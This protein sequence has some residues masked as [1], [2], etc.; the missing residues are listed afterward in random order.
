VYPHPINKD[1]C[2]LTLSLTHPTDKGKPISGGELRQ[3]L[4]D[5]E[6]QERTDFLYNSIRDTLRDVAEATRAVDFKNKK[7]AP[8]WL[9]LS[10]SFGGESP[11]YL[12][13]R[14]CGRNAVRFQHF[15]VDWS[16]DAGTFRPW[17]MEIN[18]GPDFNVKDARDEQIKSGFMR[19]VWSVVGLRG[20]THFGDAAEHNLQLVFDSGEEEGK[21]RSEK[22]RRGEEMRGK[23]DREL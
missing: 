20:D 4:I 9:S 3:H 16:I 11:Y 13:G 8:D 2:I 23:P 15:G 19:D 7:K 17:L 18:K 1:D 6:G 5:T 12:C 22:Q 10:P 14:G 21:I